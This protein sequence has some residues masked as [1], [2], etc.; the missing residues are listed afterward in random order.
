MHYLVINVSVNIFIEQ[1]FG[2]GKED[3]FDYGVGGRGGRGVSALLQKDVK[4]EF[5]DVM[6]SEQRT[7]GTDGAR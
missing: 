3:G 4:K 6:T 1:H 7:K 2:Q 5:P